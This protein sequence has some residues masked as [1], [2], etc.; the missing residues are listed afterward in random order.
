MLKKKTCYDILKKNTQGG[1]NSEKVNSKQS[2][3]IID[4]NSNFSNSIIIII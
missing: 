3:N 1:K 2:N 4:D